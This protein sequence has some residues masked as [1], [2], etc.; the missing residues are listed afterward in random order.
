MA[1]EV[2]DSVHAVTA[3]HLAIGPST[4]HIVWTLYMHLTR[5]AQA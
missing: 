3:K 1:S 4:G 5:I 2:V